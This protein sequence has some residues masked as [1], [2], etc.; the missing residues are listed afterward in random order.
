MSRKGRNQGRLDPRRRRRQGRKRSRRDDEDT[1]STHKLFGSGEEG[2]DEERDP[3][4]PKEFDDE[5]TRPSVI[6]LWLREH[7]LLVTIVLVLIGAFAIRYWAALTLPLDRDEELYLGRAKLIL[8]G[9]APYRDFKGDVKAIGY[10]YALAGGLTVF[11]ET[12]LGGRMLSVVASTSSVGLLFLLGR[13][14]FNTNVG[15]LAAVIF[16]FS[17]FTIRYGYLAKTE[18]LA[19]CLL[20]LS[21]YFLARGVTENRWKM[22]VLHG[23]ILAITVLV[24]RSVGIFLLA[25]MPLLLIGGQLYSR[26]TMPGMGRTSREDEHDGRFYNTSIGKRVK[27]LMER[28]QSV[29]GA[30]MGVRWAFFVGIGFSLVFGPA[31]IYILSQPSGVALEDYNIV[32]FLS[33]GGFKFHFRQIS[34]NIQLIM[35]TIYT[36]ALFAMA[37]VGIVLSRYLGIA[38]S[39]MLKAFLLCCAL[40]VMGILFPSRGTILWY[41][42]FLV[43]IAFLPPPPQ[44]WKGWSKKSVMLIV[45]LTCAIASVVSVGSLLTENNSIITEKGLNNEVIEIPVTFNDFDLEQVI[46]LGLMVMAIILVAAL[47]NTLIVPRIKSP[48]LKWATHI[49]VAAGAVVCITAFLILY[50]SGLAEGYLIRHFGD[51][52]IGPSL[53]I[54]II[55]ALI[56]VMMMLLAPRF[57]KG[58]LQS[59]LAIPITIIG[60]F[61]ALA[62]IWEDWYYLVDRWWLYSGPLDVV[63]GE[64]I[65]EFYWVGAGAIARRIALVFIFFLVLLF[66]IAMLFSSFQKSVKRAT[67]RRY[68]KQGQMG[69]RSQGSLKEGEQDGVAPT[70]DIDQDHTWLK[71]RK[72]LMLLFLILAI[73]IAAIVTFAWILLT[74]TAADLHILL[75]TYLALPVLLLLLIKELPQRP[76]SWMF[77]DLFCIGWF[78][79]MVL[80]YTNYQFTPVYFYEFTPIASLMAAALLVP[81]FLP[82][83]DNVET[84]TTDQ[85]DT[86]VELIP[87][88]RRV[89]SD[90]EE[91]RQ[92]EK[93]RTFDPLRPLTDRLEIM[94]ILKIV[95]VLLLFLSPIAGQGV[96]LEDDYHRVDDYDRNP[97]TSQIREVASYLH[98]HTE[99]GEEVFAYPIYA[100]E[101]DRPNIFDIVYMMTYNNNEA[102][103]WTGPPFTF[104]YP[105]VSRII[106][107][108]EDKSIQYIVVD[109]LF[110][111]CMLS[112][113]VLAEY[114]VK[115]YQLEE[116]VDDIKILRRRSDMDRFQVRGDPSLLRDRDGRYWTAYTS[117]WGEAYNVWVISTLEPRDLSDSTR[118][119]KW[120]EP[121]KVSNEV[122]QETDPSLA[123]SQDG[124]FWLAWQIN[125]GD[126][127]KIRLSRSTDGT[128]WSQPFNPFSMGGSQ[129]DPDL[130]ASSDGKLWMAFTS[131]SE[132][133]SEIWVSS[134]SDG[135]KWSDPTQVTENGRTNRYPSMI[136]DDGG[137]F[138]IAW[139]YNGR[140][141]SVPAIAVSNN[142]KNWA[143]QQELALLSLVKHSR[144]D[145]IQGQNGRYWLCWQTNASYKRERYEI[146]LIGTTDLKNWAQ[147]GKPYIL[148]DEDSGKSETS[149]SIS[150][151]ASGDLVIAY[152]SKKDGIYKISYSTWSPD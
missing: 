117:N 107:Y 127:Y 145:L 114:I 100:Y 10:L 94:S 89:K 61:A 106:Q 80:F 147:Q 151:D 11:G 76:R 141:G 142:G 36:L 139:E 83:E 23:L 120:S 6:L 150:Q 45:G 95:F 70:K 121:L 101:A 15:L 110:E 35:P 52:V 27:V 31:L 82:V 140:R 68:K 75:F 91:I 74:D 116:K 14:L 37:F 55:I 123:Q 38:T 56:S 13:R 109:N 18:P 119:I 73:N 87:K 47:V 97:S 108:L 99:E 24:R 54:G 78:L 79:S 5:E 48:S 49:I 51:K 122:T 41:L 129:S 25:E 62:L 69:I 126:S 34:M 8:E 132:G 77:G 152:Q 19:V 12:I 146:F 67:A 111:Y 104:G 44:F 84:P 128:H 118:I 64:P 71:E 88:K 22:L 134:T 1:R 98:D 85:R 143:S 42:P 137:Q 30:F 20:L 125:M 113:E 66:I 21:F 138:V 65:F 3:E 50:E 86:K 148:T 149:P 33:T 58:S 130:F 112:H 133:G 115:A 2:D 72:G 93:G 59:T 102:R 32:S 43:A 26:G 16:A 105:H 81:M 17:P 103:N 136:Q 39:L 4:I 124:A 144:P 53:I 135:I 92:K 28:S 63:R 131:G 90:V 9:Q 46:D 60:A 29:A 7:W 96:M 57:E 40:V